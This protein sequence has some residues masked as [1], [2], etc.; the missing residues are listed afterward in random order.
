MREGM[1]VEKL[2]DC[3]DLGVDALYQFCHGR[4]ESMCHR[5]KLLVRMIN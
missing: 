5:E 3:V 2:G 1:R 4:T